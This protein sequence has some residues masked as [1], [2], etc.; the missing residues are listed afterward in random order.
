MDPSVSIS[1]M[2]PGQPLDLPAQGLLVSEPRESRAGTQSEGTVGGGLQAE[3]AAG[4]GRI[5]DEL[6]YA[7][8]VS[9]DETLARVVARERANPPIELIE[10]GITDYATEETILADLRRYTSRGYE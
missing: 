9:L 7:E 2:S 1:R 3:Q 8:R 4:D 5:R 10:V 6:G